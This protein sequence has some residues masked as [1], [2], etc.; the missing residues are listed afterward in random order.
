MEKPEETTFSI[1][2]D[3]QL[4]RRRACQRFLPNVKDEES[5]LSF[6][7]SELKSSRRCIFSSS[8]NFYISGPYGSCR[9]NR[10]FINEGRYYWEFS[11]ADFDCQKTHVRVGISNIKAIIE[12]P[13]GYDTNGYSI[14]DS[15]EVFHNSESIQMTPFNLNDTI[16][17][18]Y[19]TSEG[20]G[21]LYYWVNGVGPIKAFEGIDSSQEWFPSVSVYYGSS[22]TGSFNSP[23]AFE[24]GEQWSPAE[25]SPIDERNEKYSI[26]DIF[27]IIKRG[28]LSELNEEIALIIDTGLTPGEEHPN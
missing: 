4:F 26:E 14:K 24:P 27:G 13:I 6:R 19:E 25:E 10:G 17:I 3:E 12:A 16:G 21:N 9:T 18:G 1:K 7:F 20:R 8:N 28:Q 11:F 22:V 5:S 23:F 15:G 2:I